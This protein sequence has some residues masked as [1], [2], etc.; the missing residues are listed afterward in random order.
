MTMAT[1]VGE[2]NTQFCCEAIRFIFRCSGPS[3]LIVLYVNTHFSED[4]TAPLSAV[5][6]KMDM[7]FEDT[8]LP[9]TTLI[10]TCNFGRIHRRENFRSP[11]LFI[12]LQEPARGRRHESVNQFRS[13]T[14]THTHTHT[15][16]SL[17]SHLLCIFYTNFPAGFPNRVVYAPS[18]LTFITKKFS[19]SVQNMELLSTCSHNTVIVTNNLSDWTEY[20]DMHLHRKPTNTSKLPL[21]C[22]V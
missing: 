21:Y 13:F 14:H 22:D 15:Q 3:H 17:P 12:V 10:T 16:F 7:N 11:G 6:V 18:C 8:S 4:Y 19:R 20:F 9:P 1:G 2:G 5:E